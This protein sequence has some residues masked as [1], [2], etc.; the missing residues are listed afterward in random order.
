MRLIKFSLLL[1]SVIY[2]VNC[3]S[4][5]KKKPDTIANN[6]DEKVVKLSAEEL[7]KYDVAYFA[8]GC[9]WCVEAIFEDIIVVN[10]SPSI[11]YKHFFI[12]NTS[13][14]FNKFFISSIFFSF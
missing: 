13:V 1:V 9:F 8:S 4:S 12:L 7:Q 2:S 10:S 3:E 5:T 14:F 11:L 6:K